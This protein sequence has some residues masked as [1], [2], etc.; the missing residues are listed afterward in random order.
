[1]GKYIV[2]RLLLIIPT[3]FLILLT[4]FIIVQAAPGGPVEQKIS[5][6]E[7][8]QKQGATQTQL[9]TTTYQGSR[10][11]SPDMVEAI[12]KQY[13]FDKS[14]PERFWLMLKSYA[15][16]DFGTSFFKG[17]PVSQL[18]LDKMPVSISLGLW[19]TLLIYLIAV[20]LGIAK[21]RRHNSLMDKTTALLL[22]VSYAVP[23]YV[24]A[25]VLLVMLAGG[26]YWQ[27]FPLQGLVSEN[28]DKLSTFGKIKD[29][30][31]H[32]ALPIT[33]STIGGFAGLAYLTKFSFMEELNKQYVLTARSKGLSEKKV[34]YGHV[35]RN[36]M[37]IIIAGL[38]SAIVGI[39]FTG[40][41]LIEVIFNLDGLG[42][43][44]FEAIGQ[45][46]YPVIFG[47]LFIFTLM[48][49]ILQLI[50]DVTYHLIDPRID[51]E[52]R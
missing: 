12:K 7:A 4:N 9:S 14:A 35:F 10:G 46:D 1:M 3:L 30:F 24:L 2:K 22:A 5:Q 44:G 26:S 13:G 52:G 18:I 32:L 43:L 40:N 6:I 16:G 8:E 27:I 50:S 19:S 20:P 37:M 11:L 47:T 28:F 25:V 31:W 42:R 49:L 23:V 33:A 15:K 41:F 29:Y 17:K 36:A 34:L 45:R 48:G 21:A 38:P 39:F 51:F